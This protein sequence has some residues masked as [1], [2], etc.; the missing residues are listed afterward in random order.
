[1]LIAVKSLLGNHP[2][3]SDVVFFSEVPFAQKIAFHVVMSSPMQYPGNMEFQLVMYS[4]GDGWD[5]FANQF[6]APTPGL[7]VF[8]LVMYNAQASSA[9][10]SFMQNG[11][12]LT[13]VIA[14]NILYGTGSVSVVRNLVTRDHVYS[15]LTTGRLY[16]TYPHFSGFLLAE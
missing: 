12:A 4:E 5:R 13:P 11:N 1:M 9:R 2:I 7:Y 14:S 10:V 15:R 8:N 6:I 3:E 16:R